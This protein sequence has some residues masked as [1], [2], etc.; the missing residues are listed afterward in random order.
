LQT[1]ELQFH[2]IA[3]YGIAIPRNC[4]LWNCNST[5]LQTMTM[6]LQSCNTFPA[7]FL[8]IPINLSLH[9]F[10]GEKI[11]HVTMNMHLYYELPLVTPLLTPHNPP[12]FPDVSDDASSPVFMAWVIAIANT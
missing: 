1:M 3:N 9:L 2:G 5:E 12:P 6:E 11:L 10:L 7:K 4:K 8:P